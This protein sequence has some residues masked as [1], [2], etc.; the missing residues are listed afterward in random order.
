MIPVQQLSDS[1]RNSFKRLPIDTPGLKKLIHEAENDREL[2]GIE[3]ELK[4]GKYVG[5]YH[6]GELVGF[7]TPRREGQVWWRTGAIYITPSKRRRGLASAWVKAFF[8]NKKGVAYIRDGNIASE[9]TYLAAGFH[10]TDKSLTE[11]DGVY[12]QYK[13]ED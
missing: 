4:D 6:E 5:I 7:A 11:D 2:K 8:E 1:S 12:H 13:K 9:K 10:R 3:L